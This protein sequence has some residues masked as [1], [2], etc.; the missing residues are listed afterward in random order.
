MSGTFICYQP[1]KFKPDTLATIAR[2]REIIDEYRD[3]GFSL[4]LRQLYYQFVARD[5]IANRQSEYKRLGGIVN[6]A[7][8]A[9]LI[10]WESIEDRTRNVRVPPAWSRPSEILESAHASYRENPWLDQPFYIE[11]WIEKDALVGVL[12]SACARWRLPYFSCRGYVSQSETWQA[13]QRM[14]RAAAAGKK[15]VV[16]HLGDHDPSGV[17]MSRDLRDRLNGFSNVR[18]KDD[19]IDWH[20]FQIEVDR[21]ALTMAQVR[22]F[23]PPPNPAKITDSRA[24]GYIEKYGRESWELDAL[25]PTTIDGLIAK[26]VQKRLDHAA[27]GE[28]LNRESAA[29]AVLRDLVDRAKGGEDDG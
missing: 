19:S 2:A 3:A 1:K 10:D 21:L 16:L 4:T 29:R 27:W 17:D 12:E 13:P 18:V 11:A 22:Q 7:R 25:D 24:R 9:G 20:P 8:L 15:C 23:N 6:D 28:S 26:A 14:A 5:L